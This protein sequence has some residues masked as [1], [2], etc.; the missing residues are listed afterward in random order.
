MTMN[1][2]RKKIIGYSAIAMCVLTIISCI[3]WFFSIP[4]YA[5]SFATEPERLLDS[6]YRGE[7]L[8]GCCH[9]QRGQRHRWLRPEAFLSEQRG[10]AGL[11]P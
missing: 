8:A 11:K 9:D 2:S 4:A 7:R 6:C 5:D 1:E 3:V 10:Y